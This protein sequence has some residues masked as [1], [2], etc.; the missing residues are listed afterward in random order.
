MTMLIAPG[1][2]TPVMAIATLRAPLIKKMDSL[3]KWK[4]VVRF[5]G[6]R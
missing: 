2:Q 5:G 6:R 1:F 4:K 3:Q